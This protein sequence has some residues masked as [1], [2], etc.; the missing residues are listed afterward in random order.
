MSL[1][2]SAVFRALFVNLATL[3][4]H[5]GE[6]DSG[7]AMDALIAFWSHA[8]AAVLF[9]ALLLWRLMSRRRGSRRSGCCS[10]AFALTACWAWLAAIEPG[11][12]LAA[13]A[14]TA[15]NLV[16]VGLA[17]QPVGRRRAASASTGC[18]WSMARSP[19]CSACSWSP[20]CCRSCSAPSRTAARRPRLCC[21]SPPPPG[22]LVLV[23]NLY[24]QAAPASRSHIRFA[25]LGLAAMW[26]YDL[27]LYTLGL[28]RPGGERAAW[29]TGAG[30]QWR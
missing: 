18:G 25:M 20:I 14:E 4:G 1:E 8:L 22:S 9:A 30:W 26:I 27:N 17:L 19:R 6:I 16:W 7:A 2:H 5:V 28:S 12:P 10:P 3:R 13:I 29:P 11:E 23:H 15:R 21:G 24:G